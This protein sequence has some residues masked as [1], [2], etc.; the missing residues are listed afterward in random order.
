MVGLSGYVARAGFCR[1]IADCRYTPRKHIT[2]LIFQILKG[3]DLPVSKMFLARPQFSP[4]DTN[5]VTC[6]VYV[7]N[8]KPI[9]LAFGDRLTPFVIN[10]DLAAGLL[11]D[12]DARRE[13]S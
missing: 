1:K 2:D 10:D 11:T 13:P 8:I 6:L 9:G 4:P 7:P 12:S 5:V 3:T